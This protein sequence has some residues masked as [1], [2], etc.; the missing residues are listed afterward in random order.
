MMSRISRFHRIVLA[1]VLPIAAL[2]AL[3]AA[4]HAGV[5][6]PIEI[7]D[8]PR[9]TPQGALQLEDNVQMERISAG[10]ASSSAEATNLSVGYGISKDLDV[11]VF[12]PLGLG[13]DFQ[14]KTLL[15]GDVGVT[16]L[17]ADKLTAA[18]HLDGGY[19]LF[20]SAAL[21]LQ[22]G[23]NLQY[24]LTDTVAVYTGARQLEIGLDAPNPVTLHLPVGVGVQAARP[25]FVGV[26]T[27]LASFDLHSS[28]NSFLFKD[29]IPLGAQA[30]YSL[31]SALDLYA[32]IGFPDLKHA[33]D[34]L[35]AGVGVRAFL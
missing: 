25:V 35:A 26:A 6:Q 5:D 10:G 8:R 22:L 33:G 3:T 23:V 18:A 15:E 24:K 19:D 7:I 11:H 34:D 14:A 2:S 31:S 4:A 1:T 27:T 32:L 13:P 12:Y 16:F 17:R 28:A 30:F 20:A 9:T 29:G 21:P